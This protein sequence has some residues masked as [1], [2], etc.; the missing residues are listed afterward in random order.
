MAMFLAMQQSVSSEFSVMSC[1]STKID[2]GGRGWDRGARIFL[3]PSLL[4]TILKMQDMGRAAFGE[5]ML[6]EVKNRDAVVHVGVQEFIAPE[7]ECA[8]PTWMWN[9]LS[10]SA[11]RQH[12]TVTQVK[13]PKGG[14]VKFKPLQAEF[15]QTHNPKAILEKHLR[16]FAA[17]T[18]GMVITIYYGDTPR[19]KRF[20]LE[21]V[22]LHDK[23]GKKLRKGEGVCI[24]DSDIS[25][26]FDEGRVA[27]PAAAVVSAAAS[28]HALS[29]SELK[30]VALI[31]DDKASASALPVTY[32]VG[33]GKRIKGSSV[34]PASGGGE[35]ES[36]A[37]S[38]A[39]D[40][41]A[42]CWK[43]QFHWYEGDQDRVPLAASAPASRASS[44]GG[45]SRTSSAS[46]AASDAP[47][48]AASDGSDA[49]FSGAAHSLKPKRS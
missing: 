25:C 13:L 47:G 48:S 42:V 39:A 32:F 49:P 35:A 30:E 45:A 26:D 6:F 37:S 43:M 28:R 22:E 9:Q 8:I 5:V 1:S 46:S 17:L 36:T 20:D 24:I 10:I 2:R 27:M 19:P 21:V 33:E 29:D 23:S 16:G 3:P 15:M 34:A 12:V 38:R 18:M 11:E 4:D 44:A 31:D 14:F 7:G 40:P 41:P